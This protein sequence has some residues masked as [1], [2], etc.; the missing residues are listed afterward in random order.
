M[1][2]LWSHLFA[3][4][5]L[6]TPPVMTALLFGSLVAVA[7][8]VVGVFVVVRGQA[9]L[10]HA[11]GDM[12]ATGAA[13][14]AVAG[15]GALWG[16]LVG[17]LV[18]GSA[19]DLGS[20]GATNP[21]SGGALRERD[22]TTGVVLAAALGLGALLLYLVTT[23]TSRAGAT[24]SILFGSVFTASP[25]LLGPM[26][27]LSAL[28]VALAAVLHRPLLFATVAPETAQARAVPVRLVSYLFLLAI[29]ITVE[30]SALVVGALLS[31]AL[32]IGPAAA[33]GRI[34]RT[35]AGTTALAVALALAVVWLGIVL[36]YDS[37]AW[38]PAGRGW[39]V[40]FFVTTLVLLAY[41]AAHAATARRAQRRRP[42]DG[43]GGA[44]P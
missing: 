26:V 44:G 8:A 43:R 41:L 27:G 24:Q 29:V 4:G 32:L 35:M 17:G 10:G 20:A 34:A 2:G 22:V 14:A 3:P 5:L 6:E 19:V 40:S 11:L 42:S 33:A 12:G 28:A 23:G 9:F 37:Y 13:G 15:V 30:Q 7:S 39:P 38:P 31:T 21:G 18:A 16:F 36:A 1:S 25:T